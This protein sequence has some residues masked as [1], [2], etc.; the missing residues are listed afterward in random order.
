MHACAVVRDERDSV[1]VV[2]LRSPM[3]LASSGRPSAIGAPSVE[4][5]VVDSDPN[6]VP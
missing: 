1:S 3:P 4:A 5:L 6:A 2:F